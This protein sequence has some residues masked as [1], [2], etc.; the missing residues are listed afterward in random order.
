MSGGNARDGKS[1]R[2][3]CY[4]AINVLL[5]CGLI[6]KDDKK[7]I[8]WRGHGSVE[9]DR[10]RA[11]VEK[12]AEEVEQKKKL[13]QDMERKHKTLEALLALGANRAA[14][15][16]DSGCGSGGSSSACSGGSSQQGGQRYTIPF[17]LVQARAGSQVQ[18][19]TSDDKTT[20]QFEL[21]DA[22]PELHD[23]CSVVMRLQQ[24]EAELQA[25]QRC[26][27]RRGPS[28]PNRG[29]DS[30]L[31]TPA[32]KKAAEPSACE[33]PTP[34]ANK[35]KQQLLLP[36]QEQQQQQQDCGPARQPQQQQQQ[37]QQHPSP[38]QQLAEQE[39]Q[40]QEKLTPAPP[41]PPRQRRHLHY[42]CQHAHHYPGHAA[43]AGL[44]FLPLPGQG[45]G[46]SEPRPDV[47]FLAHLKPVVTNR[48][49]LW[50]R[51]Q[52]PVLPPL[53]SQAQLQ[54]AAAEPPA[55]AQARAAAAAGPSW[56]LGTVAQPA[57]PPPPPQPA[58]QPPPPP[59]PQQQPCPQPDLGFSPT[60]S[61]LF[62]ARSLEQQLQPPSACQPFSARDC[63][64]AHLDDRGS[65]SDPLAAHL[66]PG[67][68]S[69][70]GSGSGG[71]DPMDV[72]EQQQVFGPLG[73]DIHHQ[74]QQPL[75]QQPHPQPPQAQG[76][77][78]PK[79]PMALGQAPPAGAGASAPSAPTAPS[80][81]TLEEMGE[82]HLPPNLLLFGTGDG[83]DPDP[84]PFGFGI[85]S[86][87]LAAD[88]L[89]YMM[90]WPLTISPVPFSP[91]SFLVS[92]VTGTCA[93]GGQCRSES[94]RQVGP[95]HIGVQQ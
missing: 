7:Q 12:K 11:E 66:L 4:D 61:H 59:P 10:L 51:L 44:P 6:K 81:Y 21:T 60:F 63:F 31:P 17:M 32:Q 82:E 29:T 88:Q 18:L 50:P 47:D 3:R 28:G 26:R 23:D 72:T 94:N 56:D 70:G 37:Q 49:R 45:A 34:G 42:P 24:H 22:P 33:L 87:S 79:P 8:V 40:T 85:G 35:D 55:A 25:N 78:H 67:S 53:G 91:S 30:G 46:P 9:V 19:N 57:Q 74:H 1:I 77:E 14:G 52:P 20:V 39:L 48:S 38:T 43:A 41:S 75:Q 76:Q 83:A 36:K 90:G 92:P 5:A 80:L 58:L 89:G 13:L 69:G 15:A 64:Q 68:C 71:A 93:K 86:S 62:C 95:M 84:D 65:G 54:A 2:R 73:Q 27:K 16:Q